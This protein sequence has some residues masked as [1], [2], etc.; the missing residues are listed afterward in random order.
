MSRLGAERR[1]TGMPRRH[2][3]VGRIAAA[4]FAAVVATACLESTTGPTVPLDASVTLKPG[5]RV[6]LEGTSLRVTFVRVDG[7]SRCPAD[8]VCIQGGDAIVRVAVRDDGRDRDVEL[9]TGNLQP[10]RSGDYTFT[11]EQLQPYPF[12]SKAID[13]GDYRATLRVTR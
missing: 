12:S 13:P 1:Q 7:D 10:V 6:S 5:E 2:R 3:L 8:A 9:H 11:L 4:L